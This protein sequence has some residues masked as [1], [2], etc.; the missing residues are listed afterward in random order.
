MTLPDGFHAEVFASEPDVRQPVAACFDERGRMWVIEYL[1]YP[2]PAG[3]K[4]VAV[5]QYL[6]TV[7][8]RV[9]EP[10]PHGPR[11]LDRIKILEDTNGDGRADKVTTFLEGL[12]LATGLAVGHGGVYVA[13]APYLLF[14][15]DKNKDEV[16]DGDPEVLLSGFGLEDAHAL[17]NSLA[18]GPDGWLYGAQGST[19]TANIR[20]V[21]FQQGIW[22]FHPVTKQFELFA[23]G[24]GNTWGLD[25]DR[26]G[27]IFGSSN[28][29]F[30]C[31]QMVQGGYYWKGFAKHGPLH[32]PR[33]YGYFDAIAYDGGK[34]GGHVTPGGIFYKAD[35]FPAQFQ[36][37]FIGGNLLSNALYWHHLEPR[38]STVKGKH[39]G[40]L[41]DAHDPWFRPI[42]VLTG[43]D[44]CVYVVDW[45][46][47]RA[48]HL[49]PRD[50]WDKTNG[51]IFRI[52]HGNRPKVPAFDLS[53]LSTPQLIELR[54]RPNDWWPETGRRILWERRDPAGIAPLKALLAADTETRLAM[55]DLWALDACGGIDA[56][57]AVRLLEHPVPPV[58]A[59][60]VRLL[61]DPGT[62]SSMARDALER[63]S[64]IELDPG[65][66]SQLAASC[67]RW[68]MDDALPILARLVGR[69]SDAADPFI[70]LQ[71]WWAVEKHLRADPARVV[72]AFGS[73]AAQA[74]RLV[75]AVILERLTRALATDGRYDLVARL[76]QQAPGEVQTQK[77][78]SGLEKGLEGRS[79]TEV[80]GD[81]APTLDQL[82]N[83]QGP[84]LLG[85][86][87]R[88][89]SAD[90][91]SCV[92]QRV[93]DAAV[94][95]SDR[96]RGV[97]LLGQVS[98]PAGRAALLE[99]LSEPELPELKQAAVDALGVYRDVEV[100]NAILNAYPGF[101]AETKAR[102]I[103][104]LITSKDWALQ[105]LEAMRTGKLLT[106]DLAPTQA[107]Q[108]A[109][110]GDDTLTAR[111]NEVW[112][113]LP[114][115]DSVG[116]AQRIA[117]VRGMMP[118]GD[119][120]DTRRGHLVFQKACIGCH[121][122]FGEGQAIGP[123][124]TGVERGNMEFLLESLVDPSRTIRKEY[125]PVTIALVD[126]RVLNG[127][128]VEETETALVLFDANQQ[129]TRFA[130]SDIE[131]QKA[132]TVSVM[133]EGLLDPLN[134]GQIRDLIRYLQSSGLPPG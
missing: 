18:W 32:N 125:Q 65:V 119:K 40:T 69:E 7:Y 78:I 20:G 59:W 14:Y 76:F 131:E 38:G 16:P 55:I 3:L 97:E 100:A 87:A 66:V 61:G 102:A 30:I 27:R 92:V 91:Y 58:R 124:L 82:L 31:F 13:Q 98:R 129:K 99:C 41:I 74:Q 120:G 75:N 94:P 37:V 101:A 64:Q 22:R 88:L 110:L 68:P 8:D 70:P 23:E 46:D 17:A 126:G 111:L 9:P 60:A 122:L 77:L 81:L 114:G 50:N 34:Q 113:T 71:L 105:L 54:T 36:N 103:S 121:Q 25:F 33:T 85:L 12:N 53:K 11:G 118:E 24:G 79:L 72:E 42:D 115:A 2:A 86:G 10:P 6:R 95:V 4:P 96:V 26:Q 93:R 123:D 67:Q 29:G 49:D 128:V 51:R 132:S 133:P 84:A 89:G 35:N 47:R 56:S 39:G 127:L 130:K 117:E 15:P 134:D 21:G 5:D 112:G 106:K 19:V 63:L 43:P 90:A 1:Q 83:S 62:L 28:G 116:K 52:Y 80:P 109:R 48:S 108:I 57:E 45:Y 44:G 73:P 107:R 104:Q